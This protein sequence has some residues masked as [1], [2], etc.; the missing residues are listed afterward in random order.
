MQMP[1]ATVST[2]AASP[3]S[4]GVAGVSPVSLRGRVVHNA[5]SGASNYGETPRTN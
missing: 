2:W 1:V 3:F 5:L 4:G